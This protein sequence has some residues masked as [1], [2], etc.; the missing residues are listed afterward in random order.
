LEVYSATDVLAV[1]HLSMHATRHRAHAFLSA[2]LR[3]EILPKPSQLKT[4]AT[5]K[6]SVSVFVFC[7]FAFTDF[8]HER[9]SED[10]MIGERREVKD[11]NCKTV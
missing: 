3:H 1:S 6:A 7:A 5:S 8:C 4:A 2:L 9:M 11:I 10:L